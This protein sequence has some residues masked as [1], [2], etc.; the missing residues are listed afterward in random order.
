MIADS[1]AF[2]SQLLE[3]LPSK[4]DKVGSTRATRAMQAA[5]SELNDEMKR[6]MTLLE[7]LR[8][9]LPEAVFV[10]D[11]TQLIYSGN[12]LFNTGKPNHWFNSSVGFGTL[13]YA[14]PAATGAAIADNNSPVICLIGDGGLQFVLG[15]L[16]ALVDTGLPVAILVWCNHGYR[17]IKTTMEQANVSTVGV[18]FTVPNYQAVASAYG[19]KATSAENDADLCQAVVEAFER[20]EP[21]LIELDEARLM[22]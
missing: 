22:A 1:T 21:I 18:E 11:S 6:H 4:A 17:E 8:T 2:A 15:E 13:G 19:I 10:G 12:L 5:Y 7:S 20:R 3:A 16:G 14:L 9:A